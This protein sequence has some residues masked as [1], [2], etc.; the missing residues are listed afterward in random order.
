MAEG[1]AAESNVASLVRA[2]LCVLLLVTILR[3]AWIC[4]DAYITFRS[5]DQLVHG[6]GPVFNAGERVQV[7]THPLWMLAFAAANWLLGGTYWLAI[8]LGIGL[9][10]AGAWLLAW[11]L[12]PTPAAG[13]L[14]LAALVSSVA[15]CDYAT[16][17]LENPLSFVLLGAFLLLYWEDQPRLGRLS[18]V[19]CLLA[20]NR[21][22]L[23]LLLRPPSL[24]APRTPPRPGAPA[25]PPRPRRL[26]PARR[27]GAVLPPLLRLPV[28]QHRLRQAGGERADRRAVRAGLALPRHHARPGSDVRAGDP[29][30][31]V[32]PVRR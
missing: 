25:L 14:A 18:L 19:A 10:L 5:A 3:H 17:G 7:F 9:S 27:L 24:P 32:P 21:L 15:F 1:R 20:L 31:A 4:D 2:G 26:R 29:R 28:P 6:N 12:A 30:R 11:R 23:A 8:V 13:A 22:D 16:S